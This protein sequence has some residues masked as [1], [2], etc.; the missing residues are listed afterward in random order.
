MIGGNAP[1]PLVLHKALGCLGIDDLPRFV[2]DGEGRIMTG[3]GEAE[4]PGCH[5]AAMRPFT[6]NAKLPIVS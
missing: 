1:G 3:S 5:Q 6:A 2:D 4:V